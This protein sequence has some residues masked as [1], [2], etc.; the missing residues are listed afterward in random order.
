M[1]AETFTFVEAAIICAL[2]I[3]LG[4]YASLVQRLRHVSA[5]QA[6]TIATLTKQR[7][8]ARTALRELMVIGAKESVG[9]WHFPASGLSAT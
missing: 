8:E 5:M 9:R 1:S 2:A 6:E 3:L 4:L 7:D